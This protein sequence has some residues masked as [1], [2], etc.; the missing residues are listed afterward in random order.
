[1][2]SGFVPRPPRQAGRGDRYGGE[3]R[4]G[5]QDV[6]VRSRAKQMAG[7]QVLCASRLAALATAACGLGLSGSG[8]AWGR[9]VPPRHYPG[10]KESVRG[11]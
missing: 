11:R 8:E 7:Q 6:W 2:C 4:Q 5:K 3:T 10:R 1:M 9:G